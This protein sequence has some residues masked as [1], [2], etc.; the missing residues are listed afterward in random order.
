M[1]G[2]YFSGTGNSKYALEVFLKKLSKP[3]NICSIEDKNAIELLKKSDEIVLSYPIYCSCIPKI[4]NDFLNKNIELFRNKKVFIIST[5]GLFSGDGSGLAQRRLKT[6]NAVITGGLHIR[7]P[8]NICDTKILNKS[9]EKNTDIIRKSEAYI[10]DAVKKFNSGKKL[11]QG[12]SPASQVLGLFGQRLYS[13]HIVSSYSSKI[14][15]NS[16]TCIKCGKCVMAC[17]M[18]N[19]ELKDTVYQKNKCTMCYRCLNLCPTQ[20]ITLIGKKVISQYH[21]EDCI[22]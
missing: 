15:I 6:V 17:P 10:D 5:M 13:R 4:L 22:K 18:K 9:K 8:S 3:Y 16:D 7:M 20:S 19:L 14:K 11:H 12:L 2:L 1:L 21:I